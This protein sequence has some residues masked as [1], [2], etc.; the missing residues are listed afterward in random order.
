MQHATAHA[1]HG[2]GPTRRVRIAYGVSDVGAST[3]FVAV[4]TWL[5]YSLV[6]AAGVA[7]AVAAAV[8]VVGRAVDAFLD[9][10]MGLASDRW[11]PRWGR[12]PF[13]RAGA[14]P[15]GL[16]LWGLFALPARAGDASA[17]V[18]A[19]AF[20]AV[21]VLYTVV[22]VP[23]M[24]LTPE[25]AASYRARTELTSWRVAF[26]TAASLLATALPPTLVL[27][28]A[29]GGPL[30]AAGPE[31]WSLAGLVLGAVTA[32]AYL[33]T[34]TLVP[35]PERADRPSGS[36]PGMRT[37]ALRVLARTWTTPGLR[38]LIASFVAVTVGLMLLSSLLPFVLE[39]VLR[40]P[41]A[42]QTPLLGGFFGLGIVAFPA[43]TAL[44]GR[45][46][47][48]RSLALAC[49]LLATSLPAMAALAP[50]GRLGPGLLIP[51]GIAGVALAGA[52]LLPWSLLPDLVE[53]EAARS[54]A[55]RR[56]GLLYALFTFAQKLAGS[57]GVFATGAAAALLGYRPGSVEQ[58]ATTVAGLRWALGPAAGATFAVAALLALR[59]GDDRARH[60]SAVARL[61]EA[62]DTAEDAGST[63]RPAGVA[64][65]ADDDLPASR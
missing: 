57:A 10:W 40:L 16:A 8:F 32:A 43:W 31:G 5:L 21:S 12:L 51:A 39:S 25:L 64:S 19:A 7:P 59:L 45:I 63:R 23:V 15:L 56:E 1:T 37:P 14:V 53:I 18:A 3:A 20:V 28:G 52:L 35:E 2:T 27:W 34:A 48:A 58:A 61:L 46:G 44:A 60:R 30:A 4:N 62:D 65:A 54:G 41:A 13:V 29:G 50:V 6:N 24:A 42:W 55:E 38:T 33:T 11:A 17:W 22:Q 47:K 26:G 9:P 36:G 49:S